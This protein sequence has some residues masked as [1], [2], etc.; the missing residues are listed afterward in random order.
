MG[1][2]HEIKIKLKQWNKKFEKHGSST[3][4]QSQGPKSSIEENVKS[5]ITV[6]Q[7]AL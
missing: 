6:T 2:F 3:I 4:I 7:L 1:F 5:E